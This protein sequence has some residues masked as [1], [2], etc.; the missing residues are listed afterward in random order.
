MVS[1]IVL[2]G[3]F[4]LNCLA[5]L[6]GICHVVIADT[7][8]HVYLANG[9]AFPGDHDYSVTVAGTA[10]AAP[11]FNGFE[12]GEFVLNSSVAVDESS[13]K[14]VI[15]I[16]MPDH[17]YGASKL[18]VAQSAVLQAASDA[19]F[20]KSAPSEG[21]YYTLSETLILVYTS[22]G[23]FAL[24]S[25]SSL[26]TV[27]A[28]PFGNSDVLILSSAPPETMGCNVMIGNHTANFDKLLSLGSTSKHPSFQLTGLPV[29]SACSLVDDS[30]VATV[31]L[32][33]A[34]LPHCVPSVSACIS[35]AKKK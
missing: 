18:G 28:V 6:G 8:P 20:L 1:V 10:G 24:K 32:G 25:K 12:K 21:G 2:K 14:F 16:P 34:T 11:F 7:D 3:L 4:L 9:S 13:A 23:P 22:T 29:G 17:V 26:F 15:S 5:S 31:G 19:A 33:G 35:K 30:A 27:N